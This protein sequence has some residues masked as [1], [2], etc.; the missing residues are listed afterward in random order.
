MNRAR[1][2]FT[3]VEILV[4]IVII[5]VLVAFLLP[6]LS[7]AREKSRQTTCMNNQRQLWIAL[8]MAIQDKKEE[9]PGTAGVADGNA[10]RKELQPYVQSDKLWRCP[11]NRNEQGETDYGLNF[12]MYGLPRGALTE[13]SITL[14]LADAKGPLIRTQ[15]DIDLRH[16]NRYI[17]TFADGHCEPS[18]DMRARKVIFQDGDEGEL[19]CFGV[20][21]NPISF[22]SESSAKGKGGL[23]VEGE[24]VLLTNE[25]NVPV[26]PKVTAEGGDTQP[27]QGLVPGISMLLITRGQSRAF[28]LYCRKSSDSGEK[29]N[30]TYTFG[31]VPNVTI[32]VQEQDVV[33]GASPGP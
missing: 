32:Y 33:D 27:S 12:N 2:A 10:W 17:A 7:K 5:A 1:S 29:V 31:E 25:S 18:L 21:H 22:T 3:L 11:S 23:L 8:D 24:V 26:Q 6:V 30:T 19:L 20:S 13:P 16:N 4:V 15:D 28:S 9:Y 14:A